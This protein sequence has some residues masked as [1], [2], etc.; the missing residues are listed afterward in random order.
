MIL[1]IIPYGAAV[2]RLVCQNITPDTPG[3]SQLITNM[4][5]TLERAKGAGLAAPQVNRPYRLFLV[6]AI[7]F[8]AVFI[9]ARI[10]E[11]SEE[12]NIDTEGCLS[13]PGIWEEVE[14]SQ[15]IL[16]EYQDEHFV[17][18]TCTF[19]GDIARAIQHEYD[20]TNGKLY[21]DYLPALRRS[22]LKNKLQ[23]IAKGKI[24]AAYPMKVL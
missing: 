1:P 19:S 17:T 16:L 4:W 6:T 11:Y 15:S 20:H 10:L 8:K 12:T 2:L 23:D 14:R 24:K 22:L 7:D 13:I 21:L 3:L 9:N 5:A 18:H